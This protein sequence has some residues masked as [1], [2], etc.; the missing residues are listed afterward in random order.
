MFA[1]VHIITNRGRDYESIPRESKGSYHA[2]NSSKAIRS[3]VR[4]KSYFEIVNGPHGIYLVAT[5]LSNRT[6]FVSRRI[7]TSAILRVDDLKAALHIFDARHSILEWSENR[8]QDKP[9]GS[10]DDLL[11]ILKKV[12]PKTTEEHLSQWQASALTETQQP[13]RL[14]GLA[15]FKHLLKGTSVSPVEK[16]VGTLHY[17]EE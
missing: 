16:Q 9:G 8:W 10:D 14:R 15:A 3:P 6:D 12:K 2:F 5:N 4:T 17:H 13:P 1:D 7:S 11:K